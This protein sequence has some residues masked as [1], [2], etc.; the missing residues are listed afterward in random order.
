MPKSLLSKW[1][2][3]LG[4][5]QTL[6]ISNIFT[7]SEFIKSSILVY[8]EIDAILNEAQVFSGITN[9]H[10]NVLHVIKKNFLHV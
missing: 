5:L 3:I 7:A 10:N 6:P 1:N 9:G 8:I 2:S 4:Q